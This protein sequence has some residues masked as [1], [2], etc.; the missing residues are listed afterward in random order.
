MSNL[1]EVGNLS[2]KT[3]ESARRRK[4]HLLET[5]LQSKWFKSGSTRIRATNMRFA[6][7]GPKFRTNCKFIHVYMRYD[8]TSLFW[9]CR[10]SMFFVQF[11]IWTLPRFF[12]LLTRTREGKSVNTTGKIAFKLM[13]LPSLKLEQN[14]ERVH[15][16][17]G[18]NPAGHNR[19]FNNPLCLVIQRG[20]KE[21]SR[22]YRAW[23]FCAFNLNP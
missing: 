22:A 20:R 17:C 14:R 4:P 11:P 6:W 19:L 21:E 5:T 13:A 9:D 10:W 3:S 15:W 2:H 1:L 12:K 18:L 7:T 23:K 16:K 8:L